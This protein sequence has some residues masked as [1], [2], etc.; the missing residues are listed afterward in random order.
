LLKTL[1]FEKVTFGISQ[2][3]ELNLGKQ[4]VSL[5]PTE[6]SQVFKDSDKTTPIIFVLSTGAD[7]QGVLLRFAKDIHYDSRLH[8]LSLGQGQGVKA[9]KLITDARRTGDWVCLQNCHLAKSWMPQLEK[10]VIQIS[11]NPEQC[12]DDFRLWLTS[13]P[14]DYFPVPVLQNGV[15]LTNEPPRGIRANLMRSYAAIDE[16]DF[17]EIDSVDIGHIY[18]RLLFSLSFFHAVIQERRKFGA[19]GFNKSYEFNDSDLETSMTILKMFLIDIG[20]EEEIPW[21][22]LRYVVG[23]INYGGRV[24]DDWDRRC[25]MTILSSYYTL[26]VLDD[27]GYS[28]I[29][30]AGSNTAQRYRFDDGKLEYFKEYIA[31]LPYQDDPVVFGMHENANITYQLQE[32]NAMID[33]VLSIQPRNVEATDA[34]EDKEDD[35][36]DE[37]SKR[38]KADGG[39]AAKSQDEL[40]S[41]IAADILS[42]L[43]A[44]LDPKDGEKTFEASRASTDNGMMDSLTIFLVQEIEKFNRLLEAVSTSLEELQKAIVGEVVMSATLDDIYNDLL[45]NKVPAVWKTVSY[46]SLKPLK[47]WILD[48]KERLLFINH[49]IVNGQPKSYWISAFFFQQGFIT[50]ILQNHSRKYKVPIDILSFEFE[51]LSGRYD[52]E[53]DIEAAPED[54]VFVY[55]LYLDGAKWNDMSGAM[56]DANIGELYCKMPIIHFIPCSNHILDGDRFYQCPLYKTS[57]RAGVLSTTGQS[58]NYILPIELQTPSEK[59]SKY[60]I[61]RGVALLTQLND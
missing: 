53:K 50:G 60:W 58:T 39:P 1:K 14:C 23:Q 34:A 54:G 8:N 7:P 2:F 45:N 20:S 10:I 5:P 11:E 35:D 40:V 17:N 9:E 13:M 19:L 12:H 27:A 55:G 16:A 4:F 21:D 43:P 59:K 31:D 37:Q 3:V 47:S 30:G 38:P 29:D 25:L 46:P 24:T 26:R 52:P 51:V 6:L 36:G 44:P 42:E 49:W 56:S 57:V 32:S 33:T 61:K 15:K 41:E 28:F 22:A 18:R 48:L